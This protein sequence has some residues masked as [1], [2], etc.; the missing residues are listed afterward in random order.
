MRNFRQRM[1][2]LVLAAG[3]AC[4]AAAAR[5]DTLY[6]A[7]ATGPLD[8]ST[9]AP[10][11]SFAAAAGPGSVN[12]QLQ[13][14]A[15]L[16]GDNFWIDV[17]HVVLNGTELYTLTVDL[18]GGG[19]DRVLLDVP[20]ASF[21]KSSADQTVDVSLPVTLLGGS[22]TLSLFYS[23]PTSFEGSDRAGFQGL[24]DE[25]WGLNSLV[26]TGAVPEP[27]TAWLMLGG[28]AWLGLRAAR[29]RHR[30]AGPAARC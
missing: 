11:A 27:A 10:A 13:G 19:I 2:A 23:S 28:A 6:T 16:D 3:L 15:T 8:T 26:V 12:F 30:R 9:A 1:G 5:A 18:G 17:L 24:G 29:R 20:G 25:G 7:G 14:Y 4:A 22:N 21:V